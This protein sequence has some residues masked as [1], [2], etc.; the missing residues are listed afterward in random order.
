M[1][2]TKRYLLQDI[3]VLLSASLKNVSS[4]GY[5][6]KDVLDKTILFARKYC[7]AKGVLE[8]R[9]EFG[10][11]FQGC[12]LRKK[13]FLQERVVLLRA[14][15]KKVLCVG[16]FFKDV[17][18]KT[19]LVARTCCFAKGILEFRTYYLFPA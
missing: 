2:L 8:K 13:Y 12:P 6:F 16:Y 9:V 17:L 19:I 18:S 5:V 7:F 11:L 4:L 14:S 10:I 3:I 15:L 1:S